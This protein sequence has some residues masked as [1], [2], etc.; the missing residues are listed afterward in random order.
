MHEILRHDKKRKKF[1]QPKNE[2][3]LRLNSK[4]VQNGLMNFS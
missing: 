4:S 1:K 2:F 3:L